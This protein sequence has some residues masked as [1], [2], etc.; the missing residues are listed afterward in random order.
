VSDEEGVAVLD[1]AYHPRDPTVASASASASASALNDAASF[2]D[3][4]A[5]NDIINHSY[6]LVKQQVMASVRQFFRPEFLNRLDDIVFFDPL[7]PDQL[8][9]IASLMVEELNHRLA[10]KNISIKL[11]DAALAYAVQ[12]AYDPLYGA[13]PLRRWMEHTIMTDLSRMIVSGGLGENSSVIIDAPDPGLKT[14][15][16]T[17]GTADGKGSTREGMSHHVLVDSNDSSPG[18]SPG[19]DYPAAAAAAMMMKSTAPS[20]G[21]TVSAVDPTTVSYVGPSSGLIYFARP[22]PAS[23][24]GSSTASAR[25][26]VG[27]IWSHLQDGGRVKRMG[28]EDDLNNDADRDFDYDEEM[29][30][31]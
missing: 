3:A 27:G 16:T 14:G 7:Q 5:N 20:V 17:N 2:S 28:D 15:S 12:K 18:T 31:R 13:R 19:R 30:W 21:M 9:G 1:H 4:S 26:P 29:E 23:E 10:P 24:G 8:L 6:E 22:K 25:S 11:S